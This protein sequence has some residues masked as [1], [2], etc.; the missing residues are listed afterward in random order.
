MTSRRWVWTTAPALALLLFF[1]N[2]TPATPSGGAE[3]I[4]IVSQGR[5]AAVIV[6]PRR[7]SRYDRRAAEILQSSIRKMSGVVLPIL[8]KRKPGRKPAI[9]IGFSAKKLPRELSSSVNSLKADG[10]L[11]ATAGRSLFIVSG[12]HKGSIYGAVH[13]LET[14]FGCRMFSPTAELFPRYDTLRLDP[15]RDSENPVNTFRVV[16]GEFNSST[17]YLDWQRL[18]STTE[19]FGE[20]YYVHTFQRLLPWETYFAD[21]PEYYALMNGKRIKDQLCPSNPEVLGL[22]IHEL[23]TEME[24]QPDRRIWS[25]SQNDNFSYCQCDRC[26]KVIAEEGSPAGPI[27]RFVNA[28]AER[29]PDRIISTLAYEYSRQ[30][31]RLTRPRPNVQIVL[32]TIELNRGLPIATDPSSRTFIQDIVDWGKLTSN[33]YLWDYTVNF[34]HSVS[35]FP[36][37]HILQPNIQFFVRSGARQQFE[38]TNTSPG[39]EFSE[40][41]SY[42]LARLLWNP[43]TDAGAVM[44][45][46]LDGYYGAASPFIREYISALEHGLARSG[47]RLDIY[48][49]PVAHADGFLSRNDVAAY[50]RMFDGAEAAVGG[51][52][53]LLERVR[54]A[55]LPLQYAMLEIGKDDMFGARGFYVENAGRFELRPGMKRL[56][57]DFC[58]VCARSGVTSL[59][60]SG[61]TPIGYCAAARRFIDVQVEG[62]LAFRRIV[63]A[64]PLPAQK[65]GRGDLAK[66][67][68]GVRGA[69]DFRVHWLG[70]EGVDFDLTL[71][72]G[73]GRAPL[74][75]SLSTLYDPKSWILHPRSVTCLVSSD[76]AR[77]QKIQTLRVEGDQRSEEITRTFTC[78]F[79]IPHVRFVRFHVEGTKEL[80]GWHASA[81]GRS[82]VFVDE[83][84]AR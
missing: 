66:L 63:A 37:M 12:G 64:D 83:I 33:I 11:V 80:P 42:V 77:F 71:D 70:W 19:V 25:V 22:V 48:E 51:D 5:P 81:G 36:N 29:F 24:A 75:A 84:V 65:Y 53:L 61:L 59:N 18:D 7:G 2:G 68:D 58:A 17:D 54:T 9:A 14:Y 60:E 39:H 52:A 67:T 47:A 56:L 4:T 40:L 32:C 79:E 44:A 55:R 10:F 46:F 8:E 72:V 34:S 41:K 1:L 82:W 21:H 62:N 6:I 26:R 45:E 35:P 38:Q 16:H 76:G 28:V 49:S 3:S 74:E 78:T 23:G 73:E 27:I 20:G 43:E 31:P 30:A 57:E 13:L 50:N 15:L 69:N